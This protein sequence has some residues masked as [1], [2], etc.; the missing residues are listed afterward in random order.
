MRTAP[1][2]RSRWRA[3]WNAFRHPI[4]E[5]KAR[6][7]KERWES[8]PH[9]TADEQSD[10][11]PAPDAL[12]F[13]ARRELLLVSLHALL[14]AEKRERDSDSV[15]RAGEGTDRRESPLARSGRRTADHRAATSRTPIGNQ[16]EADEL[17]EIVR[18]AISVGSIPMLMTHGQT[19]DRA[20]GISRAAHGRRRAAPDFG[21]RRHDAGRAARLSDRPHQMR[22][23]SASGAAGVHRPRPAAFAKRPGCS[24]NTRSVLRSRAATS[25]TCRK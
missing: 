3:R 24:S 9:R 6:V 14:S 12:R 10:F 17:I 16:G 19:L 18:Y 21:P 4:A 23:R 20:S 15:A 11:R 8:L 5:E 2:R 25:T 22:G 7:L 13:H 1:S